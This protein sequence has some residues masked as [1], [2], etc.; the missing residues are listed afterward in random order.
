MRSTAFYLVM[1]FVCNAANSAELSHQP[2]RAGPTLAGRSLERNSP[3]YFVDANKGDDGAA[4]TVE[5]PWKSLE[6]SVRELK[7][8]ETLVLRGGTYYEHVSLSRSGE[9]EKPIVIR[10]YPGETAVIDGGLREFAED[11]AGSWQPARD[12]HRGRRTG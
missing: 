6:R 5:A 7:P 3:H 12:R 2:M 4:G 9:P 8:G 1:T 11:P 10:S